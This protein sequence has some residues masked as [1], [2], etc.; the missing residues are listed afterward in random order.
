MNNA[1]PKHLKPIASLSFLRSKIYGNKLSAEELQ[2][3]IHDITLGYYSDIQI[4]AFLTA[5]AGGH[6]D[7]NEILNLTKAMINVGEKINWNSNFILDKH[8]IGGLPGNRTTPIIVAI[9]AAFGLTM[10]KTSSRAIT[11]PSGTADC[12]EV[13]TEVNLGIAEIRKI[14]TA[15][16][17]CLV[18][19]GSSLLSPTDDILIHIERELELDSEGQLIASILSKKIAAGSNHILIDI[20]IGKTAKV[21]SQEKA[22]ILKNYLEKTGADLGVKVKVIFT[23]GSQPVGRGIGPALEARDVLAVLKNEENAPQDLRERALILAGEVLEF[24]SKVKVGSGKNIAAEILNSGQAWKKFQAICRAQGGLRE[25]KKAKYSQEFFAQKSGVVTEINNRQIAAIAKLA[26]APKDKSAGID[27]LVKI[28]SKINKNDT[29]FTIH[30]ESPKTLHQ[31]LDY[32]NSLTN[33][34]QIS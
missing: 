3:I 26:G 16:N 34:I 20:P 30:S 31:T 8:C 13:L 12:L 29:L 10:P 32:A 28:G 25:I 23:D 27:L 5:C 24:S 11:S 15:E 22:E 14:V 33:I 19:G 21:R 2:Q 7:Q 18:W 4:A 6:L 1:N 17:G 9:V